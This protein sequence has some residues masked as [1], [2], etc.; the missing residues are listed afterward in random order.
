MIDADKGGAVAILDVK[1]YVKKECQKQL[2]NTE[3][4]KHLQKDPTATNNE[5]VHNV[6]KRFEHKNLIQKNIA[7][8]KINSPRTPPILYST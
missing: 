3:N 6:I 7:E 4:Y 2:N 8:L 5:L 1:D